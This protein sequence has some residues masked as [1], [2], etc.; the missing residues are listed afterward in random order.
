MTEE[1]KYIENELLPRLR[2]RR[3][4]QRS[5]AERQLRQWNKE[6]GLCTY[7]LSVWN[8]PNLKPLPGF[9][10][11]E[12]HYDNEKMFISQL[13]GALSTAFADGD[14]VPSVRANVG[15]GCIN[16][17][18]GGLKQTYFPDKMPWLLEHLTPDELMSMTA[19][20]ITDSPEFTRGLEQMRYMKKM[21]EGTGIE[22]Y[23]MD[24]QGPVD[25]VHLWL[26]NEFFY[27]VYDDEE[28]MH[29]ALG[30]AVDCIEYAVKKNLEIIKPD[31]YVCHYNSMALP[32]EAPL[33]ISEDTSTLI[34]KEH[35]EEY[36]IP[37][38]TDLLK[39]FG[40]GYIHYCG[41]NRHL[42][43][44]TEQLE[45]SIGLNFGNPERHNFEEVLKALGDNG[46]FYVAMGGMPYD[47]DKLV[48]Y[49]ARPDGTFNIFF[50]A[51]CDYAKQDEVLEKHRIT[52]EKVM[53]R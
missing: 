40:G 1:M 46:K 12:I 51:G 41:D 27:S 6:P 7:L 8:I 16:T 43:P 21:L 2:E 52:V 39:R 31:K 3:D 42:L 18:I 28:L 48:E 19:D 36:M 4:I 34:C 24:I 29:H 13:S 38:T 17:L 35:L 5:K 47:Y 49:A 20:D 11:E 50:G 45:G 22:V 26:G 32:V 44:I 10:N 30:L 23:P 33:K 15:C 9:N 53:K 25:M 14:A 37:Y